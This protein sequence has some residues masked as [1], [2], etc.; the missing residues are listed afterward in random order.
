MH[1][2]LDEQIV[3]QPSALRTLLAYPH[4]PTLDANRPLI[5]TGIGTSLHAC[6]VAAYWAWLLSDG[7]VQP[8]AINAHDLAL[9]APVPMNAQVVVV[10]HRGTKRLSLA[11]LERARGR[12]AVTV[13]IVG[14][15]APE[16]GAHTVIRTCPNERSGVHTVSYTTALTV[17]GQLVAGMLGERGA[18]LS[19]A[20]STVPDA[21]EQTLTK[22]APV[23]IAEQL[24]GR[25][26]L[27]IAGWGLDAITADEAALKIKEGTYQW[28][29]GL[30]T[31]Q[32]LHGP[33]AAMRAGM[34]AIT[35]TP[36]TDDGG[37]IATLRTLLADLHVSAF[38][39]GEHDEDL[40]FAPI[41]PLARPLVSIVP[42]QRLTAEIARLNHSNPDMIHR[43][44]EPWSNAMG[45][46][47]L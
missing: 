1:F 43:D 33:P 6:R 10:S 26:P 42:L 40:P 25:E 29:E 41:D 38:T 37:R 32:A 24:A 14:E 30:E 36:A 28:A 5:F 34:G 7:E 46:I 2:A 3:S 15:G 27:L 31:E 45:K 44:V 16:P 12:G 13:A 4:V 9:S 18:Q 39:C 22:P 8:L 21:I 17:L 19:T 20:L 23:A 35:I 11:A 47:V